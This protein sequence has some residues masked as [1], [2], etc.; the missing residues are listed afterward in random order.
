MQRNPNAEI[1]YI[2]IK[3]YGIDTHL[4]LVRK[5]L[6]N[7]NHIYLKLP[8]NKCCICCMQKLSLQVNGLVWQNAIF[9]CRE[10]DGFEHVVKDM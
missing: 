2:L 7:M 4:P 1:G 5:G 9:C 3:I 8:R 10:E 6:S